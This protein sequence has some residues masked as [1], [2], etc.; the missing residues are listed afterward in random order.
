MHALE[1]EALELA[2]RVGCVQ[3]VL[4]PGGDADADGAASACEVD[5][6]LM[7]RYARLYP[8]AASPAAAGVAG[9]VPRTAAVVARA[10]AAALGTVVADAAAMGVHWM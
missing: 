3:C 1:D 4:G 10:E 6:P 2:R 5:L 9:V 7:A 8:S